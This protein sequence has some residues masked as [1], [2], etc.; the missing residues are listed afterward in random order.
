MEGYLPGLVELAAT[1]DDDLDLWRQ[2][3]VSVDALPEVEREVIGLAF[4]H[5]WTQ[6]QMA[7][8]LQIDERTVR[9]RWQS[10][11]LRLRELVGDKL[12]RL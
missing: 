7:D 6:R 5:G 2:F 10:A 1:D 11:C 12:P 3:H 8:L 9:R 4:Y